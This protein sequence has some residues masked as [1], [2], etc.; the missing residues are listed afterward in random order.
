MQKR[1]GVTPSVLFLITRRS[2][3]CIHRCFGIK[4]GC[5]KE[6]DEEK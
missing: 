1:L 2:A 6:A 5:K 3:S 4:K